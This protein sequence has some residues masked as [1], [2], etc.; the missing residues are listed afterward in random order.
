MNRI[1]LTAAPSA[2][3]TR[4]LRPEHAAAFAE[5]LGLQREGLLRPHER[6]PHG[7]LCDML[8]YARLP[9]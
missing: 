5:T 8:L 7:Q 2:L 1:D 3:H 6:D 4:R 9:P